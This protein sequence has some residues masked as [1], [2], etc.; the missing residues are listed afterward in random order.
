M[1]YCSALYKPFTPHP[2]R[3]R[4]HC[5]EGKGRNVRCGWQRKAL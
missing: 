1:G 4:E 3:L 2:E 5:G